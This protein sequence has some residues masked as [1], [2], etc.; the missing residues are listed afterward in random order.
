MRVLY[1]TNGFPFPLTSGYLRHYH[2]IRELSAWHRITLLSVVGPSFRAEHAEALR[3]YT[4]RVL[5]FRSSG[6]GRSRAGKALAWGRATL[7]GQSPERAMRA[8]I[9]QLLAEQPFDAVLFSGKETLA[10]IDGLRTPPVVADFTDAA[11]QRVRGQIAVSGGLKRLALYAKLIRVQRL[12]RRI[13]ARA[14]HGLFASVRDRDALVGGPHP[15]MTV[16]PNGVDTAYW[17]RQSPALGQ[18]TLVFTGAMNYA[19]NVDA[20]LHL[21]RDILPLVQ[22]ELPDTRALIVGHSPRPA[23]VA[24][25]QRP[26]VTVTGFVDDVRPYLEQATVFVAP[27]RFGAGIQNKLLEALAMELPVI[28][29]PLAAQGLYTEDGTPPPLRVASTPEGFAEVICEELR[30]RA[31]DP[32][33]EADARRF[34]MTHFDWQ[35]SAQR[36]H[37]VLQ[38][39]VGEG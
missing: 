4:E 17:Q 5:T 33:P 39:V 7:L 10:A 9:R 18:G 32:T 11:S 19:P 30:A 13:L 28:A 34:V 6:R 38:K 16:V 2:L 25:G 26:G 23:L 35:V 24:E 3:P 29:S 36:V 20:A 37:E 8:A 21:I 27:L 1:L 22:R 12:E 15:A 14:A 31:D